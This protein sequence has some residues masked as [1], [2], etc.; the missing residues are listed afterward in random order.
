MYSKRAIAQSVIVHLAIVAVVFFSVD[1]TSEALRRPAP[2]PDIVQA[3]VIDQ[4][5]VAAEVER[6][7]AAENKEKLARE[8]EIK[9]A[10]R[11]ASELEKKRQAEQDRIKELEAERK[12]LSKERE[13]A[14]KQ[15]EAAAVEKQRAETAAK[16]AAAE[17]Q[18]R[19]ETA[20]KKAAA[21][22]QQRAEAAARKA[23]AAEEQRRL[24]EAAKKAAAEQA[25]KQ[26]REAERKRIEQ[27]LQD[28]LAL[29]EAAAQADQDAREIDRFVA[30]IASRV[31]QSFTILPGL[32]GLSCIVRITVIPG[33]EVVGVQIVKSSGNQT[34][35][36]QAETAVRKASPL[37]VPSDPRLFQQMRSISFVF[38]PQT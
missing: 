27:A 38:D 35:D 14:Q 13:Q 8:R 32:D 16:K 2:R 11:K 25:Q 22:E 37:P 30:A 17:E 24:D 6:L 9:E 29:E 28:E 34:F 26:A 4:A 19:A 15:A 36:R 1:F 12:R 23:A 33:G 5:Q 7:K 3:K 20:A 18:Q 21:E 10:E 31:R